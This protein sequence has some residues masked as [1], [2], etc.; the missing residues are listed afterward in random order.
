MVPE[1]AVTAIESLW[2]GFR[3][4]P[5]ETLGDILLLA[6]DLAA[7]P[8]PLHQRPGATTL[9]SA[10]TIDFAVGEGT[11]NSVLQE[12]TEEMKSLMAALLL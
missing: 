12:S 6:N 9:Q 4:L 5:P 1:P 8:S 7:V 10:T 2:R 3:A 11:L